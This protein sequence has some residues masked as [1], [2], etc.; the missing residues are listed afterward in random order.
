MRFIIT[1]LLLS[2]SLALAQDCTFYCC[3]QWTPTVDLED[4][5][6]DKYGVTPADDDSIGQ[7]CTFAS[8]QGFLAGY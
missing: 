4:S 6:L 3:E 1:V 7:R 5:L 8:P 2:T